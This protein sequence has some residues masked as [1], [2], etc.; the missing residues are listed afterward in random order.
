MK[1]KI[2]LIVVIILFIV[3]SNYI[4]SLRLDIWRAIYSYMGV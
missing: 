3:F 2:T 1:Q 4:Y